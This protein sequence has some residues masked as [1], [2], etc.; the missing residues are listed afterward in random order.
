MS[1]VLNRRASCSCRSNAPSDRT[2]PQ[3]TECCYAGLRLLKV[4]DDLT[5]YAKDGSVLWNSIIRK[6]EKT[7]WRGLGPLGPGR[8]GSGGMREAFL[9]TEA[10]LAHQTAWG[11]C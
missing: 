8:D 2:E 7:R 5:V 3:I 6:D 4:G 11:S 1:S 10:M 9:W